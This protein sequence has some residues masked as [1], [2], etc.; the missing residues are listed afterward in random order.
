M[1]KGKVAVISGA[2][3]GMG[4][5]LVKRLCS[6]GCQVVGLDIEAE[7]L[8]QLSEELSNWDH[9]FEGYI[10]DVSNKAHVTD[11]IQLVIEKYKTIDILVNVAGV[12]SVNPIQSMTMDEWEHT[13]SIN[14]NGVFYLSHEVSKVMITKQS[15][16]IVTVSSNAASVPRTSMSAYCASKAASLM[17]TRC[18]GL[19]LA[20]YNIRCNIV[21]PGA[22]DTDMQRDFW[23]DGAIE[24]GIKGV[25]EEYRVGIPLQRIA[26]PENIVDSILY[27]VSDQASH[28]TMN[29]IVIDGGASLGAQ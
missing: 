29:N 1:L 7:K 13:F 17:F 15:G 10:C 23:K 6:E 16:A 25:Q 27:L 18:L 3:K 11:T 24:Q 14:T 21:S 20:K 28:I 9:T 8:N 22:T 26:T 12:I 5:A 19:E 4:A 2:A